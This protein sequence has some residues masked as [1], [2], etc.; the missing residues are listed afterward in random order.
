ML[1]RRLSTHKK[2]CMNRSWMKTSLKM[3]DKHYWWIW[4]WS[5]WISLVVQSVMSSDF[6]VPT[7]NPATFNGYS[8]GWIGYL[9]KCTTGFLVAEVILTVVK[10][11]LSKPL[12]DYLNSR[13]SDKA[14]LFDVVSNFFLVFDALEDSNF[15]RRTSGITSHS[16]DFAIQVCWNAGILPRERDTGR[17][18]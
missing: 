16:K 9:W 18:R 2:L 5:K 10:S 7:K 3:E 1:A 17:Y 13:S 8:I 12:F 15:V 11:Y 14:T 6:W 4:T